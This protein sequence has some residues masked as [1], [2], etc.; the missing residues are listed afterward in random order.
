M[1]SFFV[2]F[3]YRLGNPSK[4]YALLYQTVLKTARLVIAII[5]LL[6][7]QTR[8]SMLSFFEVIKILS[9]FDKHNPAHIPSNPA[10]I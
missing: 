1:L 8:A 10:I 2:C 3:R 7:E 4:Q 6:K 9:E 5:T